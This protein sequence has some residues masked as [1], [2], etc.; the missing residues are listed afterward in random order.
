[1]MS[2]VLFCVS[3][4]LCVRWLYYG[5]WLLVVTGALLVLQARSD[6]DDDDGDGDIGWLYVAQLLRKSLPATIG[7]YKN[8]PL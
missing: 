6:D 1:M 5:N 3:L 8:H 4:L 2:K 7:E